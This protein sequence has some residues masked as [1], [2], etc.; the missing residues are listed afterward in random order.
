MQKLVLQK[1]LRNKRKRKSH[2]NHNITGQIEGQ[3]VKFLLEHS[4]EFHYKNKIKL[5]G[6]STQSE[7]FKITKHHLTPLHNYCLNVFQIIL[8]QKYKLLDA[9]L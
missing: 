8:L 5:K 4:L 2:T 1:L 7:T 9:V 3:V 6:A